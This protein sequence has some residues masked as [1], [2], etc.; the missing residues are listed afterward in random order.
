MGY[1]IVEFYILIF[2]WTKNNMNFPNF[3]HESNILHH[4]SY[5]SFN[6]NYQSNRKKIKL[7]LNVKILKFKCLIL[8]RISFTVGLY[9]KMIF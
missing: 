3:C 6:K 2:L 1:L 4:V 7:M 9:M 8:N 5:I